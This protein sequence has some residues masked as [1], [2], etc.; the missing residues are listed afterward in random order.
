MRRIIEWFTICGFLYLMVAAIMWD[1]SWIARHS[2]VRFVYV[3]GCAYAA[4]PTLIIG[5]RLSD[6]D[7]EMDKIRKQQ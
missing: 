6:L 3:C 2:F 5:L 7:G 4:V 1:I